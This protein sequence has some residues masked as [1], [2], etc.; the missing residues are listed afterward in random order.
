MRSGLDSLQDRYPFLTDI[1][2]LGVI[3]GLGFDDVAGGMRM[4]RSLYKSGLWAMF[5]GFDRRYL[6]FKL[7][8][9]AD[10]PYCDEAL[11]KLET[12]LKAAT[13]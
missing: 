13:S 4:T 12:A 1:R 6:Q 9:L 10:K 7:G 3:F 8:L 5:A 11:E 2:Q